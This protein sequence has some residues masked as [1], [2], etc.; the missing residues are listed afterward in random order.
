MAHLEDLKI[1]AKKQET[2]KFYFWTSEFDFNVFGF[3]LTLKLTLD[4]DISYRPNACATGRKAAI[5]WWGWNKLFSL[6]TFA[7]LKYFK[8]SLRH[9]YYQ[10]H[11]KIYLRFFLER[12]IPWECVCIKINIWQNI[13]PTKWFFHLLSFLHKAGFILTAG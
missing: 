3:C 10:Y 7:K 13:C 11:T 1:A 12:C 5:N 4:Y 6:D 2:S 9:K 8:R